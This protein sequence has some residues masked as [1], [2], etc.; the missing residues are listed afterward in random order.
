[1]F[2]II[3][4]VIDKRDPYG[5][6]ATHAPPDEYDSESQQIASLTNENS[7]IDEIATIISDVFTHSFDEDFP[8]GMFIEPAQEIKAA[9][10]KSN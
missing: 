1:M 4:K 9:I 8:K 2:N 10:S 5:L 6:L 7:S 3:K